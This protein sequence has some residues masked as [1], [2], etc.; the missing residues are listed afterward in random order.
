[1][2][3]ESSARKII[4][5]IIQSHGFRHQYEVAEYFG[6]TAQTLSGWLKNDI[7]PHKH[8]LKIQKE[9]H[10]QQ[11]DQ[12][13]PDNYLT[14]RLLRI[15]H[16]KGRIILF[17]TFL[18]TFSSFIYF[19]FF[20]QP[21]Y[22]AK[23]SVIPIGDS[24]NDLNNLT[25]AAAQMGLSLPL[26]NK[27]AIAW[28]ELFFEIL[29]SDGI[30]RKLLNEKFIYLNSP[31]LSSLYEILVSHLNLQKKAKEYQ[32]VKISNYIKKRIRVTK[33]RFSPLINI[34]I[35]AHEP[36]LASSMIK[37]L[38]SL[39]N[40][41][42]INMKTK[43]MG[44]KRIFIDERIKEVSKDL[45]LAET[46]L[47]SFQERNRR[48]N[49][50][51][52]LLLE[53]SRL[54]RDVTLQNNLYL[55]LKTQYEEAKIEEVERMPMVETVDSPLPPLIPDGPRVLINTVIL[56]T[57]SFILLFIGFFFKDS[58]FQKLKIA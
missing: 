12:E 20:A 24:V 43:Q 51:P 39:S 45:V 10:D 28:D 54:A 9:I 4:D 5:K 1:M 2:N 35:D 23:A 37:K 40:E 58:F 49:K 46:R 8:M 22:T 17:I 42:Q 36:L 56:G 38:I 34:E 53:E 55:T 25:G 7:I 44:Q 47:K 32:S 41:M 13:I 27:S 48:P 3:R 26:S 31:E 6:V 52:S 30:Q 11:L 15:L 57:I 14:K 16:H 19:N 21:V 18:F 50:S 33:T 29:R